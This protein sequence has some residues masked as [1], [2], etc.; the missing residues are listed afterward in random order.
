MLVCTCRGDLRPQL[1]K[2]DCAGTD[3]CLSMPARRAPKV[4]L[5]RVMFATSQFGQCKCLFSHLV[6]SISATVLLQIIITKDYCFL[7]HF[8]TCCSVSLD[9]KPLKV[10]LCAERKCWSN[11]SSWGEAVG[12]RRPDHVLLKYPSCSLAEK[13]GCQPQQYC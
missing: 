10:P 8:M 12:E 13:S 9:Q 11:L 5:S 3:C 4:F 7:F 1:L 2:N 6:N